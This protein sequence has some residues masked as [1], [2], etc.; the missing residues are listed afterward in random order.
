M[1]RERLAGIRPFRQED[2]NM[3]QLLPIG[4]VVLQKESTKRIMITGRYQKER[5]NDEATW[6]YCACL[7]P[8]GNLN[9]DQAFLFN[10]EQIERVYFLGFQD[11]EELAFLRMLPSRIPASFKSDR[12]SR[13]ATACSTPCAPTAPRCILPTYHIQQRL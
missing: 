1:G 12:H 7:Y 10:N 9:P 2:T 13:P 3:K 11:D 8:E 4:S 5:G 6:D